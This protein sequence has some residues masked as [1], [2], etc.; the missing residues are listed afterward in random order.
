MSSS[1]ALTPS[2]DPYPPTPEGYFQPTATL[3]YSTPP[4]DDTTYISDPPPPYSYP[5]ESPPPYPGEERAPPYTPQENVYQ[6]QEE[7]QENY[8][9][10]SAR[11]EL[12]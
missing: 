4:T 10:V 5:A 9:L 11:E 1:T 8:P 2:Q 7:P 12:L 6:W 3:D